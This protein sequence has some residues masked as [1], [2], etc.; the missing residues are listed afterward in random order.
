MQQT[1]G[2]PVSCGK[3]KAGKAGSG[4]RENVSGKAWV[5]SGFTLLSGSKGSRGTT[6][7]GADQEIPVPG[8]AEGAMRSGIKSR[9]GEGT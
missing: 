4:Q 9:C 1:G 2:S 7:T 8:E 6:P 5:L 3:E